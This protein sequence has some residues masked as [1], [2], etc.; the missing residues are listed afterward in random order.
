MR[1]GQF[2][3]GRVDSNT[4]AKWMKPLLDKDL[5]EER[6]LALKQL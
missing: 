6:V 5:A 2:R 1:N 4:R 3:F